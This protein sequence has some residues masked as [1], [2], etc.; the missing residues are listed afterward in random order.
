MSRSAGTSTLPAN[1]TADSNQRYFRAAGANHDCGYAQ[2]HVQGIFIAGSGPLGRGVK[3][4][5]PRTS[6]SATNATMKITSPRIGEKIG[7]DSRQEYEVFHFTAYRAP[8]TGCAAAPG[9]DAVLDTDATLKASSRLSSISLRLIEIDES[10][11]RI[12]QSYKESRVCG[13]D[14]KSKVDIAHRPAP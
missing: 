2:N 7:R 10:G 14:A 1:K 12:A 9:I 3:C 8:V 6:E 11:L 4:D 5:G 13:R